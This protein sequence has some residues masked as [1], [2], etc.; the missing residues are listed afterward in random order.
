MDGAVFS[1]IRG[2]GFGVGVVIHDHEGR[3]AAAMSKKLLQPLGLL[4]IE[5]KAMEIWVSFAWDTDI[6]DVVVESDSKIVAD[7]LLGLC[8]PPIVVSNVLIGIAYK[9]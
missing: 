3:V 8:T 5:V 6:R 7:T 2:F 1:H 4:E 9:L